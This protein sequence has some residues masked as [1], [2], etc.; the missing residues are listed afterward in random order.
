MSPMH[1]IRRVYA[2]KKERPNEPEWPMFKG[3]F[4]PIEFK[5]EQR[6]GNKKVTNIFNLSVFNLNPMELQSKLK[7]DIGC[8]VSINEPASA[9]AKDDF[10]L[11]VQ[12]NQIHQIS[13][14]LKSRN[15]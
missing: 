13:E 9:S 2:D 1:Q 5:L 14:L 12:G 7:K 11:T 4:Q 10:S 8:S 6:G 3:K 15:I